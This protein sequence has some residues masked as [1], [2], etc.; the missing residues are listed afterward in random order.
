MKNIIIG[1]SAVIICIFLIMLF[2]INN[3]NKIEFTNLPSGTQALDQP[4]ISSDNPFTGSESPRVIIVEFGDF[5]NQTSVSIAKSLNSLL[6]KYPD[7]LA[8]VWKDFPNTSLNPES[9]TVAIAARCAQKQDS[10]WSFHDMLLA[11]SD[12]LSD[13]LYLEIAQDLDVWQ[14]SFKRCLSKEKTLSWV[15]D[16]LNEAYELALPAAP[17]I[18]ING[19]QYSGYLSTQELERIIQSALNDYE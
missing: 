16:D 15:Q 17:S 14:W 5:S 6:A 2:S 12:I 7:D 19:E 13:D 11:N 1:F 4:I 8:I 3:G 10:F 9:L 18:F